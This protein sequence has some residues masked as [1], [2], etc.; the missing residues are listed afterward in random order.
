M[1]RGRSAGVA[2]FCRSIRD[3][4]HLFAETCDFHF[5]R[6]LFVLGLPLEIS[7]RKISVFCEFR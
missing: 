3:L 4:E 2:P 6:S 7:V 5:C 1:Q